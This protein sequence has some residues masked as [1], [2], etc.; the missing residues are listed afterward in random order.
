MDKKQ[1]RVEYYKDYG[2]LSRYQGF[3]YLY[4]EYNNRYYMGLQS[5]LST[6]TSYSLYEVKQGDSYDSIA[7]NFYGSPLFYWVICDYNRIFDS[8]KNPTPGTQ[9][10]LPPLNSILFKD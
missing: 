9:L 4:D 2:Y 6:D 10:K 1:N 3:P 8:L 5:N 7:Y